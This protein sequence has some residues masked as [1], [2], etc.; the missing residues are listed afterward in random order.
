MGFHYVEVWMC[1]GEDGLTCYQY[2]AKCLR[3]GEYIN[4]VE[5]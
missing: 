5:R 3:A 2:D 4:E 1:S